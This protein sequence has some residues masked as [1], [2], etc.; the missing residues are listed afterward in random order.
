MSD[1]VL[2]RIRQN[3]KR[4]SVPPRDDI[5]IAQAHPSKLLPEN[6]SPDQ[7]RELSEVDS[8]DLSPRPLPS[9][10]NTVSQTS[11]T[12]DELRAELAKIPETR[13][14]SAI[15]LEKALDQELTRFCKEQG[16]TVEL[17]LEAAW[18]QIVA[19]SKLMEATLV[20]ARRRYR[21]RKRAGQIRRLITM[22]EAQ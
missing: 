10:G 6:S 11:S 12:L 2:D 13:R 4:A 16:I 17:F 15:V 22:L 20:E 7:A 3:R 18:L 21:D 5:L 1:N 9:T 14:H 19:D 8:V